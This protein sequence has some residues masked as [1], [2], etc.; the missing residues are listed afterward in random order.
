MDPRGIENINHGKA[1]DNR[2]GPC[3]VGQTA[4]QLIVTPYMAI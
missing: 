2:A 1:E 4:Y 3:F